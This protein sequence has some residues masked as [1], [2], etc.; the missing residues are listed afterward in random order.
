MSG[1]R[2]VPKLRTPK[3]VGSACRQRPDQV[4]RV[5]R[6]G[7]PLE[8]RVRCGDSRPRA[9]APGV[10]R[11]LGPTSYALRSKSDRKSVIL[12]PPEPRRAMDWLAFGVQTQLHGDQLVT[13]EGRTRDCP[14]ETLSFPQ[15]VD[16]EG[17][18]PQQTVSYRRFGDEREQRLAPGTHPSTDPASR[19]G[20][21]NGRQSP[22]GGGS[23][24]NQPE[25]RRP[26][27]RTASFSARICELV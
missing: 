4:E 21:N 6:S 2:L 1:G 26:T 16:E 24:G 14:G 25:G 8:H 10:S 19:A 20:A 15:R 23:S 22:G 9:Q 12:G 13:I 5:L 27:P 11:R 7:A 18:Q 3:A 17:L